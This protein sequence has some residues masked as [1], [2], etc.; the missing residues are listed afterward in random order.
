[1][2]P[3]IS[4]IE[5]LKCCDLKEACR[6][7]VIGYSDFELV[8]GPLEGRSLFEREKEPYFFMVST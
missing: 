3:S 8:E 6:P 1:M 5:I 4:K 7:R 2:C